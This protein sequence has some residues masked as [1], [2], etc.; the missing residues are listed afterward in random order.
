M[1]LRTGSIWWLLA[2]TGAT[3]CTGNDDDLLNIA[4]QIYD[5]EC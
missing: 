2:M 5:I 4:E 1:W 3:H